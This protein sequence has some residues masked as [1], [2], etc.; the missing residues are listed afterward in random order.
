MNITTSSEE[1]VLK[2]LNRVKI[3]VFPVHWTRYVYRDLAEPVII[4][5]PP[6]QALKQ[7]D[8]TLAY[9]ATENNM[10]DAHKY[11]LK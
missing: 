4:S 9:S 7:I 6:S 3:L 1:L 2:R 11:L 5:C 10:L 8:Q